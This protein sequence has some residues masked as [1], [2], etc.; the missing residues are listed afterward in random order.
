MKRNT[1][2]VDRASGYNFVKNNEHNAQLILSIFL[3]PL[4][5]SGVS[6]PTIRRYNCVYTTIV[7]Y[8]SF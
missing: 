8:Y 6:R 1:C 5:V 4:H 7:T 3:Q 2:F